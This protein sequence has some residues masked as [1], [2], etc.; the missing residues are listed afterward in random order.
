MANRG[1]LWGV[2]VAVAAT[3][4]EAQTI[5]AVP[6]SYPTI[7]A[8]IGAASNG[9]IVLVSP[10]TYSGTVSFL[11]KAITVA[12]TDGPDSTT[13]SGNGFATCVVMV[14]NEGPNAVLD[15]FTI[16]DGLG[17]GGSTGAAASSNGSPGGIQLAGAS[18][19]IRNCLIRNCIGGNGAFG[20]VGQFGATIPGVGGAGGIGISGGAPEISNCVFRANLGGSGG[21]LSGTGVMSWAVGGAGGLAAIGSA[22][23]VEDCRFENNVG[24]TG[25]TKTGGSAT[26]GGAGGRAATGGPGGLF[27]APSPSVGATIRRTSF[28]GNQGGSGGAG[29]AYFNAQA[30]AAGHGG[31][32][33]C[34]IEAGTTVIADSLLAANTGGGPGSS[35]S[36][37]FPHVG[38]GGLSAQWHYNLP[39]GTAQL[40]FTTIADNLAGGATGPAI[41]NPDTTGGVLAD[42]GGAVVATNSIIRG[43]LSINPSTANVAAAWQVLYGTGGI[44]GIFSPAGT[45]A[46]TTSNIAPLQS[47]A[48]NIDAAPLFVNAPARDYRLRGGS[49]CIDLGLASLSPN[50]TDLARLP[51]PLGAAPDLGSYEHDPLLPLLVGS[52]EDVALTSTVNGQGAPTAFRKTT[53]SGDLVTITIAS[54]RGTRSAATPVLAAEVYLTGQ[55]A[56]PSPPAFPEIHLGASAAFVVYDGIADNYAT[57]GQGMSFSF[58]VPVWLFGLTARVQSV[59]FAPGVLNGIF[60]VTDAHE[61]VLN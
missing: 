16:A 12:S 39:I 3:A 1:V 15:G 22:V 19:R 32:G 57:L 31:P 53:V 54:P 50:A 43:N 30:S 44:F 46:F 26:S 52:G 27:S 8:A 7:Q 56:P 4:G 48:G 55:P 61:L 11:G 37:S 47:G 60:A 13:I 24:G 14:N 40:D 45:L 34:L 17:V 21:G 51:R 33:G 49:P 20:S 5:R 9:D 38:P 18:G 42:S 10:G 23:L 29:L 36:L 59:A 2:C 41:G 35:S 25:G 28:I 6:Q 58:V